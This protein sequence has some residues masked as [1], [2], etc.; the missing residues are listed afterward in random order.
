MCANHVCR[1]LGDNNVYRKY[2][3]L[4]GNITNIKNKKTKFSFKIHMKSKKFYQAHM[5]P[6]SSRTFQ[7]S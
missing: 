7:F 5:I 2:F 6:Q 3:S 4:V 1:V